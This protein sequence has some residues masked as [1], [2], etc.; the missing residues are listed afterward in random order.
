VQK[1]RA[2]FSLCP[3]LRF[4]RITN[5]RIPQENFKIV[6]DLQETSISNIQFH[7]C[8]L[9]AFPRA[10]ILLD[11][12]KSLTYLVFN[13]C[14]LKAI[15]REDL[16]GLES[17]RVLILANNFIE[18]LPKGLFE[19][20]PNLYRISFDSNLIKEID[21]DILD[22]LY[23]LQYFNLK[24]NVSINVIH[25]TSN[26]QENVTLEQLKTEILK[27]DPTEKLK[28]EI[29]A[30]KA[31]NDAL[32]EENERLM[33]EVL[34]LKKKLN[35]IEKKFEEK[36][37]VTH[38]EMINDFTVK[39]KGKDFRVSKEILAANSPVLA[40]LINGNDNAED[41]ELHDISVKTFEEILN[42]MYNKKASGETTDLIELFGA[43]SRL[44]MKELSDI[45]ANKLMDKIT[46]DNSPDII[47]LA[48][49]YGYKEL[50][51]KAVDELKKSLE[52][53]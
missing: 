42:F 45:T 17:L 19:H 9:V 23:N 12:V 2:K 35:E 37:T 28:Q 5:K 10:G 8:D 7:S 36:N 27:C 51:K 11:I 16:R 41:L 40:Q 15:T 20:T 47:K 49:K 29:Y 3:G 21:A 38:N 53:E 48:K 18:K 30:V 32:E 13:N 44:E 33:N 50:L 34:N 46:F 26:S 43:S 52:D 22:P 1:V 4:Y 24:N 25:S 39:V 14:K 6:V 31:K